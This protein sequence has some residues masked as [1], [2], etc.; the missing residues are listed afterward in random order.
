MRNLGSVP[1]DVGAGPEGGNEHTEL[2]LPK[3]RTKYPCRKRSPSRGAMGPCQRHACALQK[4]LAANN[5]QAARCG[6]CVEALRACCTANPGGPNCA[7]LPP[8]TSSA[9]GHEG[10]PPSLRKAAGTRTDEREEKE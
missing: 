4:C 8:T 1:Y 5:Y 2:P 10:E 7:A 3:K 6:H 9:P